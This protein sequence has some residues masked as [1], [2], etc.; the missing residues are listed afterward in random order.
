MKSF[1]YV[2]DYLFLP[3]N[4][5]NCTKFVEKINIYIYISCPTC[6]FFITLKLSCDT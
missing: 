4:L 2:V 5:F 1:M 3:L 6:V